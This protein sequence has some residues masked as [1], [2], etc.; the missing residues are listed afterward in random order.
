VMAL[1]TSSASGEK[2]NRALPST[3]TL[4]PSEITSAP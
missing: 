4:R 2:P 3:S 1:P